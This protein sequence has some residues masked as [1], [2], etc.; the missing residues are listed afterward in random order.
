MVKREVATGDGISDGIHMVILLAR[1][2]EYCLLP[3]TGSFACT[4]GKQ[5]HEQ[6][7]VPST[8][9]QISAGLITEKERRK[10]HDA[11][12]NAGSQDTGWKR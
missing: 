7:H 12:S 6:C 8:V 1:A 10:S 3:S 4:H 2:G 11:L 5:R 9:Q